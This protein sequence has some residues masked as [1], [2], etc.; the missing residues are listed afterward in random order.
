LYQHKKAGTIRALLSQLQ[1]KLSADIIYLTQ[2]SN[3][4]GAWLAGCVP[5]RDV[6]GNSIAVKGLSALDSFKNN[7]HSYI[8][9]GLEPEFDCLYPCNAVN[10]LITAELVIVC[11]PY[12]TESMLEYADIILPTTTFA[13]NNGTYINIFGNEQNIQPAIRPMHNS[14]EGW[15]LL[16]ELGNEL[17]IFDQQYSSSQEILQEFS[18]L[19]LEN[20]DDN[21]EKLSFQNLNL[22]IEEGLCVLFEWP[23]N[24]VDGITRR[25]YA[26]QEANHFAKSVV[27]MNP[28]NANKLGITDG[29]EVILQQKKSS[30]PMSL[31]ISTRI[32]ENCLY[33]P[34][35]IS[36][37]SGLT[38][39]KVEVIK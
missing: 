19:L 13:E 35:G 31:K 26:L 9:F 3:S 32:P 16:I 2:G 1:N 5:H 39:G 4:V 23:E 38:E 30:F 20:K 14:K 22:E 18:E 37:T 12:I 11:N 17:N 21:V 7:L 29:E 6:A 8:I 33:V 27:H 25:S 36:A 28:A 24:S 10:S 34:L 15:K